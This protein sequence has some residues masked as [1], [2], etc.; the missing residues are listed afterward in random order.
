[1]QLNIYYL[2]IGDTVFVNPKNVG[3]NEFLGMKKCEILG[4]TYLLDTAM[5]QFD[6]RIYY[7]EG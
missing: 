6:L 4:K 3:N 5:I 7:D 2:T 1:L